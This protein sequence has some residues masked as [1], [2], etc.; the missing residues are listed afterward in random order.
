MLHIT[1][2]YALQT[3]CCSPHKVCN[4]EGKLAGMELNRALRDDTGEVLDIIAG[5]FFIA[6]LS[7]DSFDSLSEEQ[8]KTYS[9]MY[10]KPEIF[11]NLGGTIKALPVEPEQ[12]KGTGVSQDFEEIEL[13]GKPAL[14]SNARVDRTS[15][16]HGL[17][18]YDIRESE[19]FSGVPCRLERSVIVNHMGTVITN[20][21]VKGIQGQGKEIREG[22]INFGTCSCSSIQEYMDKYP[23]HRQR[24]TE[25]ER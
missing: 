12:E 1:T 5:P 2:N 8:I 11:I 9:K 23:P 15:L 10:A 16:P 3:L 13:F 17:Y 22:D 20:E 18:A 7:E 4:D 14:F 24:E 25:Y 21:A 6:G 19:G